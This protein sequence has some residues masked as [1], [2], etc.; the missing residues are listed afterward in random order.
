MQLPESSG[1]NNTS[2]K[3]PFA[4]GGV[5]LFGSSS[6]STNLFAQSKFG[7]LS[8]SS[9]SPFGTLGAKSGSSSP[10]GGFGSKSASSGF[11]SGGAFGSKS[12]ASP[13]GSSSFGAT[14]L[15]SQPAKKFGAPEL[16]EDKSDDDDDNSSDEGDDKKER[17]AREEESEYQQLGLKE[18]EGMFSPA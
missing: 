15:K 10:F 8:G 7:A 6:S 18:Q 11:G 17:L 16:E 4:T 13:F 3:S 1:F 9:S 12:G 14:V 5:N 2:T